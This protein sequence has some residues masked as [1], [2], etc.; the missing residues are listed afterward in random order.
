[1]YRYYKV[2]TVQKDNTTLALVTAESDKS[3]LYDSWGD[4]NYY[5]VDTEDVNFLNKQ[6]P[7][8]NVQE[9]SF[10]Q[11]LPVIKSCPAMN[12][13]NEQVVQLIREKYSVND[14]LK[15]VTIGITNPQDPEYLEHLQYKEKCRE[16]GKQAK[17]SMGLVQ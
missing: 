1:M 7:E 6:Y 10:E 15:L 17:I 12:S 8:C 5:G 16:I 3:I 4:T 9:L 11:I 13:A 2:N 14:E